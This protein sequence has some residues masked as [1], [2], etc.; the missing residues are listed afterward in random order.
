[1]GLSDE[2]MKGFSQAMKWVLIMG[3]VFF[4]AIMTLWVVAHTTNRLY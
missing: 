3:S 2:E 4:A 1:M